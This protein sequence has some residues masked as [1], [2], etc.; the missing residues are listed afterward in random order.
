MI[1]A[2]QKWQSKNGK[3]GDLVPRQPPRGDHK[4]AIKRRCPPNGGGEYCPVRCAKP[5][6]ELKYRPCW[7]CG[8]TGH[9]SSDCPQRK[10]GRAQVVDNTNDAVAEALKAAGLLGTVKAA[11]A[12]TNLSGFYNVEDQMFERPKRTSKP[13]PRP[14]NL[15]AFIKEPIQTANKFAALARVSCD[16]YWNDSGST[17]PDDVPAFKAPDPSG[18]PC[19][20]TS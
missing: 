20:P 8:K 10:A 18:W 13:T 2:F 6:V 1:M 15:G 4:Y 5:P 14:L 17:L 19:L 7:T 12:G 9:R 16:R 3:P 11:A